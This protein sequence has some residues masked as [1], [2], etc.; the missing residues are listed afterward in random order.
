MTS[1]ETVA[2][3]MG[4][5]KFAQAIEEA[6]IQFGIETAMQ[7]AHFLAQLAHESDNFAT[8]EEYASGSAYEGRKDLGNTHSG[9]GR[10]FKGRG[11][12]QLTGRANYAAYSQAMYGDDRAIRSPEMLADLPDAALAAGWYWDKRKINAAASRDDL[13]QVTRLINGGL[14]GIEDRRAKLDKA[15]KLFGIAP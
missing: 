6:C 15:K 8:A 5:G 3:A 7:K 1:T 14:N 12:I 10:R 2:A 4:A 9:D 11:L 13:V